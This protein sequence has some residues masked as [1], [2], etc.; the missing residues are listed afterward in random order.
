M[1]GLLAPGVDGVELGC[2]VWDVASTLGVGLMR[3]AGTVLAVGS[4][5]CALVVVTS[6]EDLEATEGEVVGSG[7]M[8]EGVGVG[9]LAVLTTGCSGDACIVGP[10]AGELMEGAGIAVE[11]L[12]VCS[13]GL[14]V[15]V[16]LPIL[17]VAAVGV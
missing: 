10:C 6:V 15:L 13:E 11:F 16:R 1:P 12:G 9:L 17:A 4:L 7:V 8:C 5:A 14:R 3:G 2:V